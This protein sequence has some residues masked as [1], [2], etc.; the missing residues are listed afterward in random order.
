MSK[1]SG[2]PKRQ[3][4]FEDK[5]RKKLTPKEIKARDDKAEKER[6]RLIEYSNKNTKQVNGMPKPQ[7]GKIFVKAV[8]VE[9]ET[10][11][12]IIIS[13]ENLKATRADM[14]DNDDKSY[15]PRPLIAEVIDFANDLIRVK[16]K[17]GDLIMLDRDYARRPIEIGEHSF[18][19]IHET[20]VDG[21]WN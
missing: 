10:K 12:G 4:F 2:D 17:K 8:A 21:I 5:N 3:F 6:L 19:M 16:V 18:I 14:M 20:A 1:T 13:S 9:H 11:S 7:N 15:D